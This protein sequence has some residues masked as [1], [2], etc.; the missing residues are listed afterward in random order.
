MCGRLSS[1]Q[2][3]EALRFGDGVAAGVDLQF[4]VDVNRVLLGRIGGDKQT[5]G[6]LFVAQVLRQ[7][8]KHFEL[9][10]G[11]RL[12]QLGRPRGC[13]WSDRLGG[14]TISAA[15]LA[16]GPAATMLIGELA[17]QSALFGVLNTLYDLGL[18][19]VSVERIASKTED[20]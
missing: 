20:L 9:A 12:D 10:T 1:G 6:D 8:G 4:L 5:R 15:K 16:D 18:P 3:A 11:Q 13:G 17:D 2:Q 14:M 19:L 7:Q